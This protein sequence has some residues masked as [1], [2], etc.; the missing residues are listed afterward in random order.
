MLQ[1]PDEVENEFGTSSGLS[2]MPFTK[3][4]PTFGL[5]LLRAFG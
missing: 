2:R 4:W 3:V 5:Y 1:V